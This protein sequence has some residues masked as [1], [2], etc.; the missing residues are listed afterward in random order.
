[1]FLAPLF[2]LFFG[3]TKTRQII[4]QTDKYLRTRSS[5]FK[6]VLMASKEN[7]NPPL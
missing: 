6:F 5:A 1:M 2:R 4:T 7:I 3:D